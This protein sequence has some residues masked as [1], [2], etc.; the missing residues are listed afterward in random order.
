MH[1]I[2]RMPV[3]TVVQ[4]PKGRKAVAFAVDWPGRSR[5]A[6]TPEA[7]LELLESDRKRYRPIAVTAK[8]AKE[9]DPAGR[10]KVV[11]DRSG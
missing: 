11:E 6:K 10:F 8:L 4:R 9:F 5:G 2:P 3:R 1:A 7:A